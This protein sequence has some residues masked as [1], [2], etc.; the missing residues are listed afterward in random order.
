MKLPKSPPANRIS[1][2]LPYL[3]PKS[4]RFSSKVLQAKGSHYITELLITNKKSSVAWFADGFFYGI[5]VFI[6]INVILFMFAFGYDRMPEKTFGQMMRLLSFSG[7]I[8]EHFVV[9]PFLLARG[10]LNNAEP[11][12]INEIRIWI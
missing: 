1:A 3:K 6:I 11:L 8:F 2:S 10:L 12:I 7:V 9:Q 5:K 4:L